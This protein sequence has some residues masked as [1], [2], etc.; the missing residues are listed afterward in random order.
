MSSGPMPSVPP[1]L[2]LR[3]ANSPE[4]SVLAA[5]DNILLGYVIGLGIGVPLAHVLLLKR[6]RPLGWFLSHFYI[7]DQVPLKL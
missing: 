1:T 3:A 7:R 4:R 5:L 6:G 2:P